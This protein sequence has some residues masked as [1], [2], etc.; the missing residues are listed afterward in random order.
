LS[1]TGR[2]VTL[3][4]ATAVLAPS[5]RIGV[6]TVVM[7]HAV[8]NPGGVVGDGAILNTGSIVE[9]DNRPIVR[10]GERR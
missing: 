8:V 7:A 10:N 2:V 5:A 4:H 9:H 3:V 6:G 1:G